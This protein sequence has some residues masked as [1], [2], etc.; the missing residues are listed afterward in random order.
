MALSGR[1]ARQAGLA[2]AGAGN[3]PGPRAVNT[4]RGAM[5]RGAMAKGP[6][7]AGQLPE[8]THAGKVGSVFGK[9]QGFLRHHTNFHANFV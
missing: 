8:A 1:R 4:A 3:A 7:G 9:W 2:C 6:L 5:A